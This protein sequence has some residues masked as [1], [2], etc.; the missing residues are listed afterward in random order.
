MA[1]H[2]KWAQIKHKK[3]ITDTKRGRLFS[4]L[5]REIA[6]AAKT[7][8]I[9]P[10]ANPRLR[11]AMERA[12]N[13]GLPKDNIERARE[14]AAGSGADQNLFEFLYEA[15]AP[16]GIAML[17]EGIT[18]NKNR[19][20]AELKH[21]LGTYGGRMAES[22]S[23]LWN[24]EKRGTLT[25]HEAEQSGTKEAIE[26]MIIDAGARDFLYRDGAWFLETDF[27]KQDEA[28]QN[29]EMAGIKIKE[30]GH[31]YVPRDTINIPEDQ[32]ENTT[33]L[34][35]ALAEQDD[36]REVYT[37]IHPSSRKP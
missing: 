32:R 2:S 8:G 23:L 13:A 21:I 6:V 14:R 26:L 3:A 30:M 9:N 25:V 12:K 37:N 27:G 1:G 20:T 15:S 34:L 19:T 17:I 22:G 28:R 35:E 31:D 24:F 18:D 29:L 36:V 11:A 33:K 16:G 7:G 5:A 4:G 10:D